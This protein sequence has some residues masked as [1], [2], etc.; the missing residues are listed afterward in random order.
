MSKIVIALVGLLFLP[1]SLF[2][3][4]AEAKTIAQ[5]STSSGEEPSSSLVAPDKSDVTLTVRLT[6]YNAVPEQTDGNP[7]VTA[8]GIPSNSEVIA[9]RSRDLAS[10]LPFG[11]VIALYRDDSDTPGCGF[12]KVEHLIGYR[13]VAD[14][15]SPRFTKRIDV[16]F[17]QTDKVTVE[18]KRMNPSR[19]MGVCS[20]VTVKVLGRLPLTK[21]PDSQDELAELVEASKAKI[22][23]AK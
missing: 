7:T 8:S 22:A 19:A 17:D 16:E 4:I 3:P 13:V 5:T 2:A 23:F 12:K 18:G 6:S 11:T 9:A 10:T 21:I 15:M 14:T 1:V 20:K